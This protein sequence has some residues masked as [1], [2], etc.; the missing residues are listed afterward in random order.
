MMLAFMFFNSDVSVMVRSVG[1]HSI[2]VAWL[3]HC[4]LY[5]GPWTV[6]TKT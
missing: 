5:A 3:L 2:G 6:Y 4:A 1:L